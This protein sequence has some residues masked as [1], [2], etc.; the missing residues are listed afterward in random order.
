MQFRNQRVATVGPDLSHRRTIVAQVLRTRAVREAVRDEM[1]DEEL[2]RRAA[3]E[4][5]RGYAYEIA[6][7]YSHA[8]IT[9]MSGVLGRLWNR[10]YDGVEIANLSS[11]EAVDEGSEIIYVPCHRSHMDY[12]LLS[13][14]VYHKGHAVPH[15]AQAST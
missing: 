14:V 5:A 6:A 3:L 7:N 1:R 11:L 12:L 8:F 10:L 2:E 4:K 13:Y 15:I 9:F